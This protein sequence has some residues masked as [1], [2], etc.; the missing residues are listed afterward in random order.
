MAHNLVIGGVPEGVMESGRGDRF[1]GSAGAILQII[2][3]LISVHL[4]HRT[5]TSFQYC[6]AVLGV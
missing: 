2:K 1:G 4:H 5:F 3:E 6:L